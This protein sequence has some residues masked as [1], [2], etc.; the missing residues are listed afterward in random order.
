[1]TARIRKARCLEK[2]FL[3]FYSAWQETHRLEFA[4]RW[5]NLLGELMKLNPRYSV[6]HPFEHAF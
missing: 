2:K 6:R 3:R 1:M 4:D 5:M